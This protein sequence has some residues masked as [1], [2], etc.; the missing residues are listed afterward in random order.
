MLPPKD[1]FGHKRSGTT[2]HADFRRLA[3]DALS[4]ARA[5]SCIPQ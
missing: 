4:R 1:L 3:R 5:G 2:D